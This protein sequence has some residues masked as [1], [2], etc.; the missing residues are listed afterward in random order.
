MNET[1]IIMHLRLHKCP[2]KEIQTFAE[3]GSHF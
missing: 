1:K 3:R 2:T